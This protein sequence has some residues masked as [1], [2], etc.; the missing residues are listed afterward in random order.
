MLNAANSAGI[1]LIDLDSGASRFQLF[2][3]KCKHILGAWQSD[4]RQE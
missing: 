2:L 4:G 3:L 1:V